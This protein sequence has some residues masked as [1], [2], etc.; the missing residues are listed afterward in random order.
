MPEAESDWT[1]SSPTSDALAASPG[2]SAK[3]RHGHEAVPEPRRSIVVVSSAVSVGPMHES[4]R[5][6]QALR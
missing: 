5:V 1:R 6:R 3:F 2:Q 4:R